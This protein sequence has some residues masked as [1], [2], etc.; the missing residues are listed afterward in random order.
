MPGEHAAL[1]AVRADVSVSLLRE[2]AID[3]RR[4]KARAQVFTS[5]AARQQQI[6]ACVVEVTAR[7]ESGARC[8]GEQ[9]RLI[10][11][12]I[13][14]LNNVAQARRACRMG[15]SIR[16]MDECAPGHPLLRWL[17][18]P[19]R[20]R[21][22][23]PHTTVHQQ[24]A[25]N[26]C[27]RTNCAQGKTQRRRRRA[28]RSTCRR[29][30]SRPPRPAARTPGSSAR[31][32]FPCSSA[33]HRRPTQRPPPHQQAQRFH[34]RKGRQAL[35]ARG[36]EEDERDRPTRPRD[37][38]TRHGASPPA[39]LSG[40]A[41]ARLAAH[42]QQV[43]LTQR[44]QHRAPQLRHGQR[45]PRCQHGLALGRAPPALQ[46]RAQLR[47]GL[48]LAG[49]LLLHASVL[50]R[51]LLVLRMQG[52]AH[53]SQVAAPTAASHSY[54]AKGKAAPSPWQRRPWAPGR[55]PWPPTPVGGSAV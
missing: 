12:V 10:D 9:Q 53:S 11:Q 44:A 32:P 5:E 42:Q 14:R 6:E 49:R 24:P 40:L 46:P 18:R 51:P 29:A 27:P 52:R 28:R 45:A 15:C 26:A 22:S 37:S 23:K 38:F 3:L 19:K 4:P 47:R 39:H 17:W 16:A 34:A 35:P 20:E 30:W 48:L 41:A 21:P 25:P 13:C 36:K 1:G 33:L 8:A 50:L 2:V 31:R 55:L 7:C 54:P 43:V